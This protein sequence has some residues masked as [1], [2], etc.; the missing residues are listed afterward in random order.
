MSVCTY[1]ESVAYCHTKLTHILPLPKIRIQIL[2]LNIIPSDNLLYFCLFLFRL[3]LYCMLGRRFFLLENVW[4]NSTFVFE[5]V[6]QKLSYDTIAW[7]IAFNRWKCQNEMHTIKKTVYVCLQTC[8]QGGW[9]WKPH[10]M[11]TLYSLCILVI[12]TT[13]LLAWL[14]A[15][16]FDAKMWWRISRRKKKQQA[17]LQ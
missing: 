11:K 2:N 12:G 9:Y 4:V 10:E 14:C 13:Y 3:G 8:F 16:L 7:K 15:H 5:M 17:Q 1:F 6:K